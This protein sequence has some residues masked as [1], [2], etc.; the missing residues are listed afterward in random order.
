MCPSDKNEL[1]INASS[2]FVFNII[3]SQEDP[4]FFREPLA[5]SG[6]EER[7]FVMRFVSLY[8]KPFTKIGVL[9]KNII[10]PSARHCFSQTD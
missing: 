5:C 2:I 8:F 10:S 7:R 4:G 1:H 9:L 6:W 3:T